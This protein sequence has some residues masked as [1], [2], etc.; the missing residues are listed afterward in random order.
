MDDFEANVDDMDDEERKTKFC[1]KRLDATSE[2]FKTLRF[3]IFVPLPY[4]S[5]K[6]CGAIFK[7]SNN[8]SGL[9]EFN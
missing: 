7:I 6:T 2:M 4:F 8:Y 5:A 9:N 3:E 1:K